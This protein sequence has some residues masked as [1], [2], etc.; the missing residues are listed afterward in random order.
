MKLRDFA[1]GACLFACQLWGTALAQQTAAPP[2]VASPAEPHPAPAATPAGPTVYNVEG[3]VFL[4][5]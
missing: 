3:I 1:L 2:V 4:T 5:N